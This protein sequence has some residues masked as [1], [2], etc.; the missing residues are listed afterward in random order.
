MYAIIQMMSI[1]TIICKMSVYDIVFM[2]SMYVIVPMVSVYDIVHDVNVCHHICQFMKVF[3]MS[4]G[5]ISR[6]MFINPLMPESSPETVVPGTMVILT[7][8]F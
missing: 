7:I 4:M 6:W 3:M 2:I 5:A 8:T 1:Y